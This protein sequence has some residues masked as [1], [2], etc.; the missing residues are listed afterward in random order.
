MALLGLPV[1]GPGSGTHLLDRIH[2]LGLALG[3]A[4]RL[5]AVER[6]DDA[7]TIAAEIPET[8][9]ARLVDELA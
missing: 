6:F 5:L 4:D 1:H 2:G 3:L 8:A 9:F 7:V